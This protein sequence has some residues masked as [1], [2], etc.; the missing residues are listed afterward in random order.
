M[1]SKKLI[2]FLMTLCMLTALIVPVYAAPF[3][4]VTTSL[5]THYVDAINYMSDNGIICGWPDGTFRPNVQLNRGMAVTV[6]F[7]MSGDGGTYSASMFTDVSPSSD[8]YNAIGWAYAKG[9]TN[10][11]TATTFEPNTLVQRQQLM[12]MLY[13]FAGYK[14]YSQAVTENMA[15]YTDYS[16]VGNF[17]K[18]GVAWAYSYAIP[19]NGTNSYTINPLGSVSRKDMAAFCLNYRHNVEGIVAGRDDFSFRNARSHFVSGIQDMYLMSTDD[20]NTYEAA[21]NQNEI[22][23]TY[24]LDTLKYMPWEGSCFGMSVAVALDYSGKIDLNGNFCNST[25]TMNAIP[26]LTDYN[27]SQHKWVTTP[28]YQDSLTISSVESK[29]NFFQ[30]SW[31]LSNINDWAEYDDTNDTLR[32]MVDNQSYGGIGV[33]CYKYMTT[34][35]NGHAINIY[36]KPVPTSTGYRLNMYDN[37]YQLHGYVEINTTSSDWTGNIVTNGGRRIEGIIECSYMNNYDLYNATILDID[38]AYNKMASATNANTLDNYAVLQVR[39]G[40]DF[41]IE[42]A[43]GKSI[44]SVNGKISNTM[45]IYRWM[46]VPTSPDEPCIIAFAVPKSDSY[47]CSVD[48]DKLLSFYV[49]DKNGVAGTSAERENC[50]GLSEM[51]I[52]NAK[53]LELN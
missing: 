3:S 50:E 13:R 26:G 45:D 15:S 27:N 37:R 5:G 46:L 30:N 10:G 2:A 39:A 44:S 32:K 1:K 35:M 31:F 16:S 23:S 14:G 24:S 22:I 19:Y 49:M 36:G 8:Y 12:V 18:T 4:D 25:A 52:S 40:D 29:I 53:I 28:Q 48:G 41:L 7:R 11:T 20:W 42:T 33:F 9:I 47:T 43:D 17:A 38:G 21:A 51:M 6:L 34:K